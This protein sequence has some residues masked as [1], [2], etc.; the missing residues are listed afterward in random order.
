[1]N[2]TRLSQKGRREITAVQPRKHE[3]A[4][5]TLPEL[6]T[7]MTI[8]GIL[9]SL[10]IPS[11][12]GLTNMEHT[13]NAATDLYFSLVRARSEAIKFNNSVSLS[14]KAGAWENGW[15]IVNSTNNDVIEDH[16]PLQGV[17][18]A[19]F[20]GTSP[21][22]YNGYGRLQGNVT[23]LQI[24]STGSSAVSTCVTVDTGGRPYTKSSAC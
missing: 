14:P 4:G 6:L 5:F 17:T 24:T 10:A 11:F 1:M 15:Q 20:A 13:K 21:V 9:A 8:V 22:V 16:E 3:A 7:T 18:V 23:S 12:S 19:L 2:T